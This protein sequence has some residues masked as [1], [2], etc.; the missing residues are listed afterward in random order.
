MTNQAGWL[1]VV[2]SGAGCYALKYIG[3]SLPQR[4]FTRS[5]LQKI[6]KLLPVA[7][8]SALIVVE[9]I[10]YG[11]HYDFDAARLAGFGMGG[12]VLWRKGSFLLVVVAAAATA[13]LVRLI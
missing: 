12:L 5:W 3:Y 4:L 1:I 8:L 9:A 11:S 7:L 10:A 2:L 13:A 6:I